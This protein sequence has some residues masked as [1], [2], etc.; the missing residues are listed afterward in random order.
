MS[1]G[2]ALKRIQAAKTAN[3]VPTVFGM[4]ATGR[5]HLSAVCMLAP[6]L[7]AENAEG[8]L[9]AA[10][11]QSKTTIAK[12]LAER[13]SRPDVPTSIRPLEA[14]SYDPDHTVPEAPHF[15]APVHVPPAKAAPLS[16]ETCDRKVQEAREVVS[17][18]NVKA[19]SESQVP[20]PG[21]STVPEQVDR[22][23]AATAPYPHDPD[24]TAILAHRTVL[25]ALWSAPS[26]VC[27]ESP[28]PPMRSCSLSTDTL[29]RRRPRRMS[30]R[31][32]WSGSKRR[33]LRRVDPSRLRARQNACEFSRWR[34]AQVAVVAHHH[35]PRERVR[36]IECAHEVRLADLRQCDA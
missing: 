19:P 20:E 25:D 7:T 10:T 35:P 2:V 5:L 17:P 16:A 30:L 22:I 4:V 29:R 26:I 31:A 12:L 28:L 18:A 36:R 32:D 1:E 15:T 14:S 27:A 13:F 11:H 3:E 23:E 8:L 9:R 6:K 33:T 34:R 21:I 24:H